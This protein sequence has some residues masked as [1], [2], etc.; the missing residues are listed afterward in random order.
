MFDPDFHPISVKD[1]NVWTLFEKENGNIYCVGSKEKDRFIMAQD[2][3]KDAI[4]HFTKDLDG[5]HSV[6]ELIENRNKKYA[7]NV[8]KLL[9]IL[10][11]AGLIENANGNIIEKQELDKLSLEIYKGDLTKQYNF[12]NKIEKFIFPFGLKLSKILIVLGIL[13]SI[14]NIP[15]FYNS[16]SY[17]IF[18]SYELGVIVIMI[19]STITLFLHEFSHILVGHYKGLQPKNFV[20]SLY[21]YITPIVYVK[22]PGIY[23]LKPRDRIEIFSAGIYMNLVLFSLDMVIF[24]ITQNS[25]FI[26]CAIPNLFQIVTNISPFMPLDGY[27][28]LST[29]LKLPNMRKNSFKL[30]K[31][32]IKK[33]ST[34]RENKNILMIIYTLTS[35]VLMLFIVTSQLKWIVDAI[36]EAYNTSITIFQFIWKLKIII[37]VCL[38]MLIKFI[39][40]IYTKYKKKKNYSTC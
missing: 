10:G 35:L 11:R 40:S 6:G 1:I 25:I 26:L 9:E 12:Y 21:M 5:S 29:I 37:A 2:Y 3:N 33:P 31:N 7:F 23:T 16:D 8:K 28:M 38:V 32:I 17:N 24:T 19:N 4:Y 27:L 22:T 14:I 30:L 36:I 13:S 15:V 20:I 39:Y 34:I 18:D